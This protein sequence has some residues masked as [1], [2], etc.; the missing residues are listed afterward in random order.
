[1]L[2]EVPKAYEVYFDHLANYPFIT[3]NLQDFTLDIC[4]N[5]LERATK[6]YDKLILC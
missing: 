3:Q 2:E 4:M 6:E 1:M 5:E